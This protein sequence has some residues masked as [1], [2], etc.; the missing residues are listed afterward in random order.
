[1][2]KEFFIKSALSAGIELNNDQIR[3]FEQYQDLLLGWNEKINLTAITDEQGVIVKHFTDSLTCMKYINDNSKILDVGTGAGFPGIPL[4]IMKENLDVTLLDSL[5]KRIIYLNDVI[6]KLNLT[7]INA[8][9]GRAEELGKNKGHRE[10]Y[11]FVT[12]RAVANLRVLSEYCLPFVKINGCFLAMK[13]SNVEEEI[14]EATETIEKL[15]GKVENI[16]KI[17][18]V[19]DEEI[20]HHIVQIRKV[21]NTPKEFPRRIVK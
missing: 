12:A 5:N 2:N 15:G 16:E 1:M 19:S 6:D 4:K 18:L 21:K 8:I 13:G 17:V 11:D 9:H 7:K 20:V 14:T 3:Q 10:K